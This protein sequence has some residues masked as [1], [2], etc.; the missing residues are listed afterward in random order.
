MV[1]PRLLM[2]FFV[3]PSDVLLVVL[4]PTAENDVFALSTWLLDSHTRGLE[5]YSNT[6]KK[7]IWAELF[8]CF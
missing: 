5:L 3:F 8:G 2:A 1:G 4:V 6:R 7:R